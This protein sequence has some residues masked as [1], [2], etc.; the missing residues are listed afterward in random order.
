MNNSSNQRTWRVLV[1]GVGSIGERHVR[2]FQKTG[3]CHVSICETNDRLR[4]EISRRYDIAQQFADL[5]T[6]LAEPHDAAVIAVPADL[7]IAVAR[8]AVDAG[9][10]LL[11]EK[12]LDVTL[13]GVDKLA[14]R[15]VSANLVAAVGYVYRAHPALAAMRAE[16]AAGF[17]GKPV[18]IVVV[19]GQNFPTYRPAYRETYYVSRARGGGAIQDAMTHLVNAAEWLVGPIERVVADADHKLVAGVEV[20]DVVHVLARHGDVIGSYS[21]NQFQSPN[22]LTITVVCERGTARFEYHNQRWRRMLRPD[23]PWQDYQAIGLERDTLFVRQAESFLDAIE[24][25]EAPLCSLDEGAQTLRVNLALMRSVERKVWQD[26]TIN[27]PDQ[28]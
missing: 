20:E 4:D 2:C 15:V 14:E 6:A 10:H 17:L 7:H 19:A 9:L 24:K 1:I 23:D 13:E 26:L 12:P 27:L 16:I 8:Q 3:R 18:Q 5:A 11:I 22:E 21:L 28:I 25:G